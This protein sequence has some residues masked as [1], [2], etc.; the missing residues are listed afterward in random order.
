MCPVPDPSAPDPEA[1]KCPEPDPP[2]PTHL[3]L[4]T[5]TT[6]QIMIKTLSLHSLTSLPLPLT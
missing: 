6:G 5:S 3:Y 4:P 1:F 2:A